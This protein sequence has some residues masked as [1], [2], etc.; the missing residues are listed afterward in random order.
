MV[1]IHAWFHYI[2]IYINCQI[3]G[4][5]ADHAVRLNLYTKKL[6]LIFH[7]DWEILFCFYR[8]LKKFTK[9]CRPAKLFAKHM[10]VEDQVAFVTYFFDA[11]WVTSVVHFD[12]MVVVKHGFCFVYFFILFF[13]FDSNESISDL[14]FYFGIHYAFNTRC[15]GF[16][17]LHKL[18]YFFILSESC[19]NSVKTHCAIYLGIWC[20]NIAYF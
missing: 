4:G 18:S 15:S 5:C 17:Y 7:I 10:K 13:Q 19:D 6:L 11:A 2:C 12:Y 8:G 16:I 20:N 3:Y 14:N 1:Y 9:E